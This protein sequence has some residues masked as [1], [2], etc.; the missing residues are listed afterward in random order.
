M[1][2]LRLFAYRR[3]NITQATGLRR[4][5]IFSD[6]GDQTIYTLIVNVAKHWTN[7][8]VLT[9][10][11]FNKR[12]T[13]RESSYLQ[14]LTFLREWLRMQDHTKDWV[15]YI[16]QFPPGTK[17]RGMVEPVSQWMAPKDVNDHFKSQLHLLERRKR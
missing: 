13:S 17:L 3:S 6:S 14:L 5:R 11:D 16:P 2:F 10:V 8:R 7:L 4:I 12:I 15:C 9:L 1:E